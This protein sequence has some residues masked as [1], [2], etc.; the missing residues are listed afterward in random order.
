[1]KRRL[2]L[3]SQEAY[4]C[5]CVARSSDGGHMAPYLIL[6]GP[7]VLSMPFVREETD[8]ITHSKIP[9]RDFRCDAHILR[10]FSC[11]EI[12]QVLVILTHK[13]TNI[14]L[15]LS[16]KWSKQQAFWPISLFPP[17]FFH[18]CEKLPKFL[19]HSTVREWRCSH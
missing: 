4:S 19:W 18:F 16:L 15:S 3:V 9:E 14:S 10:E 5:V 2:P 7:L 11:Q 12:P 8:A 1:M 13:S 6:F 17:L